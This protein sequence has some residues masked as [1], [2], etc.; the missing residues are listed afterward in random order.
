MK[1]QKTNMILQLQTFPACQA[2][3]NRFRKELIKV[4]HYVKAS[5]D[6]KFNITKQ[7]LEHWVNEFNRWVTNGNKVPIPPGHD[8]ANDPTLNQGWVESLFVEGDSLFGIL[9]LLNPELA[10]VTDVSISVPAEVI[11]GKGNKYVNPIDHV[12]LCVDPVIGGLEGFDKLSLSNGEQ[13]MELLK[14]IAKALKLSK[15]NPTEE[16]VLLALGTAIAP[17]KKKED[18]TVSSNPLVKLVGENR[19]IK[20]S[21]LLKAGRITP[22]IKELISEKYV[23]VEALTLELSSGKDDGAFDFLFNILASNSPVSLSE[24]SGLQTLE[25][26]N[27]GQ[28]QPNAMEKVVTAKR[29]AAGLTD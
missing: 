29:K 7:T 10:K 9:E 15:D 23:K 28:K 24:I 6:Q 17:A 25:L 5:T 27:P 26:A 1:N 13:S 16:E 14:K 19:E 4:G 8:K 21:G 18:V 22:A 20:L 12:A 3:L 11:D 2:G